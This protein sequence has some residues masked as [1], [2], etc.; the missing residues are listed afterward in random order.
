MPNQVESYVTIDGRTVCL[1]IKHPSGA[2]DQ[3]FITVRQF[4]VCQHGMLSVM[5]GQVC[6]LQLLLAL[7]SQVILRSKT[8]GMCDHILLSQIR[9][10][11]FITSCN[12]QIYGRD[13]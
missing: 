3:I 10:F 13:I 12:L 8:H 1:G 5:T 2:Y 6:C 4:Q 9:D 7:A 11:L